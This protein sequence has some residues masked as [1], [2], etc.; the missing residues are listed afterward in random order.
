[1]VE[2]LIEALKRARA[3]EITSFALAM[4]DQTGAVQVRWN[5][6]SELDRNLIWDGV[7]ENV[8]YIIFR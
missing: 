8:G 2:C 3:G 5:I 4:V 7:H 1:M 6:E